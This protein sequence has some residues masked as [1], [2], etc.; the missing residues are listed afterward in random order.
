MAYSYLSTKPAKKPRKSPQ[1]YHLRFL[2]AQGTGKVWKGHDLLVSH[3]QMGFIS[4]FK[5][6]QGTSINP[7]LSLNI[8]YSIYIDIY[9]HN[10]R[11]NVKGSDWL[12]GYFRLFIVA[13][14][15]PSEQ[16]AFSLEGSKICS[17][18]KG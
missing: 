6:I 12:V 10:T 15:Y 8:F 7:Y 1:P 17:L 9:T 14:G 13:T 5:I 16:N 2:E 3:L 18:G 11:I 4:Y